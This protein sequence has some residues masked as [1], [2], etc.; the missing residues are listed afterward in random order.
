MRTT[1][2]RARKKFWNDFHRAVSQL[3]TAAAAARTAFHDAENARAMEAPTPLTKLRN[4]ANLFHA[5]T[6][7]A[8]RA[9]IPMMTR[10]TG[11]RFITTLK[12][13]WTAV[14][15]FVAAATAVVT[16]L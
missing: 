3:A 2:T 14:H 16:A 5:S 13:A 10:D 9:T 7:A 8:T 15:T 1:T 12:A 6:T 11:L 4:P